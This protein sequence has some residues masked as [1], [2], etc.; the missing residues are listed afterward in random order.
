M[1]SVLALVANTANCIN[2]MKNCAIGTEAFLLR[3]D[4]SL[5]GKYLYENN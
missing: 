3:F 2:G 4:F 1:T 5:D